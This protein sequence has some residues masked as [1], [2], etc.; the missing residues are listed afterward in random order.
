MKTNRMTNLR[1]VVNNGRVQASIRAWRNGLITSSKGII[2]HFAL[3]L[4]SGVIDNLPA[5][6]KR[7]AQ[8]LVDAR[9]LTQS[10]RILKVRG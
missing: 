9:Y 10:G 4:S 7:V 1:E 3:M 6:D 2:K 5:G 8:E